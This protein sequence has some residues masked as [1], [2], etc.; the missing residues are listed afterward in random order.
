VAVDSDSRYRYIGTG[1]PLAFEVTGTCVEE[2]LARAVEGFTASFADVHPS[3]GTHTPPLDVGG[4][5]PAALLRAVLDATWRLASD[6]DL[7]ITLSDLR[8]AA[9]RLEGHFVAVPCGAPR[10]SCDVPA[11]VSWH[12]LSLERHNGHWLGRVVAEL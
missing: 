11:A 7:A 6:G 4:Q 3:V 1:G 10:V 9:G 5:D 12:D 8:L 2:C